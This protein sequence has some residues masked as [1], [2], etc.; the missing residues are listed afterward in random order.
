MSTAAGSEMEQCQPTFL[1]T[2]RLVAEREM[3]TRVRSKGY[4]WMFAGLLIAA[5]LGTVLPN[6]IGGA[7]PVPVAV[8]GQ[9]PAGVDDLETLKDGDGTAYYDVR[10]QTRDRTAA[11][12]LLRDGDVDAVLVFGG[13]AHATVVG[14]REAPQR[15]VQGL[16]VAPAVELLDPSGRDPAVTY[17]VTLAFGILFFLAASVFGTQIAQSVV[18]EKSTRIVEILLTAM[19]A[20]ALLTGKVLGNSALAILQIVGMA[21][22]ALGGLAAT[23][24]SISLADLSPA[25]LWFVVFFAFGFV[26][27]ASL[28]AAT[29]S[30]VSRAEDI[31]SATTPVTT[32][33]MIPYLLS[34]VSV[35]NETLTRV[36]A[37]VPFSSPISMPALIFSGDAA[38]WEPIGALIVL[39][40]TTVLA[41]ALGERIYS[42]SLL[43]TGSRVKW[44]EALG[45]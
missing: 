24:G 14:L 7:D 30:L 29:A 45:R 28:F 25:I 40:T 5:A 19:S 34:F 8:V 31:G 39:V 44:R 41:I 2:V 9:A 15:A 21:A 23:G 35:G 32:L 10:E 43:R 37:W 12:R 18:E 22:V 11:D 4:R 42:N 20:R 13:E 16:S 6:V 26:M 27:V 33:V 3:R 17:F 1:S 38:W 36:L